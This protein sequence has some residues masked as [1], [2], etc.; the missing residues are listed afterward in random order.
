MLKRTRL[1]PIVFS[2][3]VLIGVCNVSQSYAGNIIFP[4]RAASAIVKNGNGFEILFNNIKSEVIDSVILEGPFNRVILIIDSVN[5]GRFEYD[6]YTHQ[7]INNRIWVKVPESSPEEIYDLIVKSG[8]EKHVSTH[9][10]K[11]VSEFNTRHKFIH[12]TDLH[13]SRQWIGQ[14]DNGYAKELELLDNFIKVANIINPDFVIITGD[15]IHDYTRFNADS[16]GW[17]GDLVRGADEL[18]LV[19]EKWKNFYEGANGFSGIHGFNAP[20][21]T[22]SGNHDFYGIAE[23]NHLAKA[24][25]WNFLCGKRVFGF[26]Y[27]GTRVIV[28]D[29]FLGDPVTDIPEKSPMSGLQ[30]KVLESYLVENGEGQIRIMA[31]H[32]YNRID[33]AFCDEH[34]IAILLNGHS[35]KPFYEYVGATPTISIRPGTISKSGCSDPEKELGYFRI[36]HIDGKTYEFNPALRFCKDPSVPYQ[37]LEL[38]LTLGYEKPNDGTSAYNKATIDNKFP[39]DLPG[40]KIRFIMKKGNYN[41]SGG[42]I[43]QVIEA[44]KFSILDVQID[45]SSE[46]REIIEITR[47]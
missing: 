21:F 10:V 40:C 47:M 6:S 36:F 46:K 27:A 44:G 17:G 26:S 8:G 45:V 5:I 41:V 22:A 28:S 9:S 7:S 12:I 33:T 13:I 11:V 16:T 31:Q 30:G 4:W 34:K 25:Q 1:H 15:N 20:T 29:D 32:R 43:S 23:E 19:E 24:A 14:A 2:V 3:L 38:N 39:I 18:P 37:E 35:H 42:I